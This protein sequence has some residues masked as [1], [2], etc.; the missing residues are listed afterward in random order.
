MVSYYYREYMLCLAHSGYRSQFP[1]S[2]QK[3][4]N[5]QYTKFQYIV[6]VFVMMPLKYGLSYK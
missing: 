3:I 4:C 5:L 2:L 6:C 1:C